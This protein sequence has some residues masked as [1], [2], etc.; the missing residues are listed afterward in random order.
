VKDENTISLAH[1]DNPS[2]DGTDTMVR[3]AAIFTLNTDVW[4]LD[5][6][7]TI[8]EIILFLP[9]K[10]TRRL[11]VEYNSAY[12]SSFTLYYRTVS[13]KALYLTAK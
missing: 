9:L 6:P 4:L 12:V 10:G 7:L 8:R 2:E 3:F 5:P 11:Y 13:L 1:D